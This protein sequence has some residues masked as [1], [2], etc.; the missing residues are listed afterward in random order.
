MKN[1]VCNGIDNLK[2]HAEV[3]RGK[4]I[5]LMTNPAG[6]DREA[7]ATLDVLAAN[8]RLT[9]LFAP[10]HG[11]RG[12]LQ[13]GAHVED[14]VDIP[15]GFPCYTL[16]GSKNRL[17]AEHL[18]EVDIMAFDLQ[19]VGSRAF[20]YLK[21]LTKV[22]EDCIA[23]DKP[24]AVFDR[25]NPLGGAVEGV[26]AEPEFDRKWIWGVPVRFG[27]TAGEYAKMV[28]R[29]YFDDACRLTVI[30]CS[31][32]SR[33]MFFDDCGLFWINPTPN[34]PNPTSAL[35]YAGTAWIGQ[36]NLSEA[37]GTTRPYE[38]YGAPY[39]DGVKLEKRLN[40]LELPGVLFRS[41]AFMAQYNMFKKYVDE[42]C[43]GVRVL[44]T[45]KRRYNAF[46]TGMWLLEVVRSDYPEFAIPF[47][48]GACAAI[49][50]DSCLGSADWRTGRESTAALL[51]RGRRESAEFWK[52]VEEFLI[53]R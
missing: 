22:M 16:Y 49:T 29:R 37:R 26:M 41:C 27:L 44:I 40:A 25:I 10:E 36:T 48:N 14:C 28:N 7:N 8:C 39:I 21:A 38:M 47:D 2:E 52:S 45:D 24:L 9:T 13:N 46:E 30:P 42:M 43:Y 5:G 23:L 18:E 33:D 32:W 51:E 12:A 31:G 3:F 1:F 34:L 50:F 6:I 11:V 20:T 17:R 35:I 15:T 53:Y 4:R 19:D